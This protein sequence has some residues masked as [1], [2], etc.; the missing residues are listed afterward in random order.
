VLEHTFEPI[1]V[2]D[3]ALKFLAAGDTLVCITP[4]V[5]PIHNYP[6]D[7]CRL[8]PDFYSCY[9]KTRGLKLA[10]NYFRYVG[11]GPVETFKLPD[12]A[13]ILPRDKSMTGMRGLY[14]RIIHRAFN[15]YGRGM[16]FR[17]NIAIGAVFVV[18]ASAVCP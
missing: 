4:I 13:Y 9:A 18:P 1:K 6:I 11:Y 15:T 3:N 2:L 17:P 8:L 14:S 5:W 16:W 10:P 7:V 12:G